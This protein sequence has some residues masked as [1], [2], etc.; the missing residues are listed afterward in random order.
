VNKE[1]YY[2]AGKVMRVHGLKGELSISLHEPE[3]FRNYPFEVVFINP[4]GGPVPYFVTSFSFSSEKNILLIQL[5]GIDDKAAAS[6]FV[7]KEVLLQSS[8]LPKASETEFFAHEVVGY[9]ASDIERGELGLIEEVL[10]LPMQQVFKIMKDDKEILIPAVKGI[11]VKVD[12]RQ[13]TVL[14]QTPA[15]LIDIYLANPSDEEE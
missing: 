13:K 12:R 5:E 8:S 3:L 11:L 15:G 6:S 14:L 2:T 1:E 4:G 7:Q 9:M 10:D